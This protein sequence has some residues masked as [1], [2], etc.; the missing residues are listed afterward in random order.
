MSVTVSGGGTL[1]QVLRDGVH[2]DTRSAVIVVD[3]DGEKSISSLAELTDAHIDEIY[4][5]PMQRVIA[6]LQE[7]HTTNCERIVVVVPTTGMSGGACYAPQAALAESARILVKSAAR[8]WGASGITVNAVAVE[9]HWFSIDSNISG[10]VAIAPRSLSN[11][12]SP[13]GVVT[14]LC[15]EAARDVTGQTIVCDGGLWM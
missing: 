1:A 9:P 2:S 5:Q 4:E 6:A 11:E 3:L 7:A 15:S 12:V 8:Q 14:W 10:P 13:V